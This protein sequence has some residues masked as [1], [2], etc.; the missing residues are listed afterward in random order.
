MVSSSW[1]AMLV[2]IGYVSPLNDVQKDVADKGEYLK[3]RLLNKNIV[4]LRIT[5]RSIEEANRSRGWNQVGGVLAHDG[6]LRRGTDSQEHPKVWWG[7]ESPG[8]PGPPGPP[9]DMDS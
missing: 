7:Y 1:E 4:Q 3:G 8:P 2:A 5:E 9:S 6:C